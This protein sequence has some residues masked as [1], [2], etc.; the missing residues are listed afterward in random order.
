MT[1]S[2]ERAKASGYCITSRRSPVWATRIDRKDWREFMASQ[3]PRG[4]EWVKCLGKD[5]ADHYRRVYSQDTIVVPSGYVK[6]LPNSN[7]GPTEFKGLK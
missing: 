3:H 1:I 6:L 7:S 5:A 4:M 2:A